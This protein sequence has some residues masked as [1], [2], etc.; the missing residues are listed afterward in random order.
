MQTCAWR[1]G[2]PALSLPAGHKLSGARRRC[3]DHNGGPDD[4]HSTHEW[5]GPAADLAA[6][7][8][9][10]RWHIEKP[11]AD[12]H[13]SRTSADMSRGRLAGRHASI[14]GVAPFRTLRAALRSVRRGTVERACVVAALDRKGA[15]SGWWHSIRRL[16]RWN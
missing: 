13:A 4:L 14:S 3:S 9:R 16:L 11:V 2:S 8:L 10:G 15:G 5:R 6:Q 12:E 7:E 1:K